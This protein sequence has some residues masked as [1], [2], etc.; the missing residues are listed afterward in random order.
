MLPESATDYVED[1][2]YRLEE[3]TSLHVWNVADIARPFLGHVAECARVSDS[4]DGVFEAMETVLARMCT[5]K[6]LKEFYQRH[7][8]G[9]KRGGYRYTKGERK[10]NR[11]HAAALKAAR[12]M[13]DPKTPDEFKGRLMDE[14]NHLST[15]T[16]VH[17]SHPALIERALTIMFESMDQPITGKL[18]KFRIKERQRDYDK[19]HELLA[20]IP[21][22]EQTVKPKAQKAS[23]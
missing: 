12:L 18:A 11:D 20:E 21:D 23:A 2:L 1:W 10:A 16:G 7:G 9:K 15:A 14:I 19:M 22:A 5:Q 17:Y 13:A 4:T 3:A 6:E 8:L